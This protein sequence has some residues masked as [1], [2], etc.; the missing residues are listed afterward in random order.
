MTDQILV[1]FD[2]ARSVESQSV[3]RI[4]PGSWSSVLTESRDFKSSMF[5]WLADQMD[6]RVRI[7]YSP[8]SGRVRLAVGHHR[9]FVGTQFEV[10]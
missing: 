10:D 3:S 6:T 2:S 4:Q 1:E 8:F 9:C 5:R 7:P